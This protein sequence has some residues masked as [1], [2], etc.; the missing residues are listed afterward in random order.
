MIKIVKKIG[1]NNNL[2]PIPIT[3]FKFSPLFNNK[4]EY[5]SGAFY[6]YENYPQVALYECDENGNILN[7]TPVI[8]EEGIP[9]FKDL[10]ISNKYLLLGD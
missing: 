7:N 2:Y 1:I 5:L 8:M 4:Y 3:I 10:F 9:T 6:G